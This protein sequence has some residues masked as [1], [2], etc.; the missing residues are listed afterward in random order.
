MKVSNFNTSTFHIDA[1]IRDLRS[2][3]ANVSQGVNNA[4]ASIGEVSTR[5]KNLTTRVDN[6]D[7]SLNQLVN[8]LKSTDSSV[9]DLSTRMNTAEGRITNVSSYAIDISTRF[10]DYF[11]KDNSGVHCRYNFIGE[12]EVTAFG[13]GQGGGEINL[14]GYA[15][16]VDISSN[17]YNKSEIDQRFNTIELDDYVKVTAFNASTFHIDASI[18]DLRSRI[19]DVSHGVIDANA[20]ISGIE[21]NITT[22]NINI[23]NLSARVNDLDTYT[24]N[25]STRLRSTDASVA[26][27]STRIKDVSAYAI[28]VSSRLNDWFYFQNGKLYTKYDFIS[29]KEICAYKDGS[30]GQEIDYSRFVDSSTLNNYYTKTEVNSLIDNKMDNIDLTLYAKKTD[31]DSYVKTT[32]YNTAV[33]R[34]N[35][36]V[37][38]LESAVANI[39]DNYVAYNTW[40]NDRIKQNTS[41]NLICSSLGIVNTSI[42]LICSSLG[43]VNTSIG[44]LNVSVN[45]VE[46]WFTLQDGKLVTAYSL[47]SRQEICAY[48]QGSDSGGSGVIDLTDYVSN[49]SMNEHWEPRFDQKYLRTGSDINLGN[50]LLNVGGNTSTG[51]LFVRNQANL[52]SK[53]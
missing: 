35:S 44:N 17:Y 42:N 11:W 30:S 31:L 51:N 10:D 1:S 5:L 18:R 37:T 32:T 9:W 25:I 14:Q 15:K 3:I 46:K 34:L 36:S 22:I 48:G 41:I 49:V 23:S 28:N 47:I 38:N 8:N 21:G 12:H 29:E 52:N 43:K 7:T 39:A 4:N 40:N 24:V 50:H 27:L 16:W 33:N 45:N 13:S 53:L 2:R 20:S 19:A 26:D 6:H